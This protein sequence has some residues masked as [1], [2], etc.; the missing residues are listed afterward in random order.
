MAGYRASGLTMEQYAR[1]EGINRLTLA[2]WCH[3]LGRGA[4]AKTMQFAEVKLGATAT[5][6]AGATAPWAFEVEKGRFSWPQG[7]GSEKIHLEPAALTMPLSG[8]D[9]KDGCKKLGMSDKQLE[10]NGI[11]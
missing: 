8:I 5:M 7:S 1:R 4:D 2:K 9:L 3:L 10:I 6:G 11:Q